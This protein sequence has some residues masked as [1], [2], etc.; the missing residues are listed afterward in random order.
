MSNYQSATHQNPQK[1]DF[2]FVYLSSNHGYISDNHDFYQFLKNDLRLLY[3]K[4]YTSSEC[5]PNQVKSIK[6]AILKAKVIC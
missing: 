1:H 5:K 6:N 3:Q 4:E 2:L